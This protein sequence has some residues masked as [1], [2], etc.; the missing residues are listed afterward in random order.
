MDIND[1]IGKWFEILR[2][3]PSM[4]LTH[5]SDYKQFQNYVEGYI[6]GLACLSGKNIKL[7]L[8]KWFQNKY[9]QHSSLYW[10][11]HIAEMYKNRSTEELK[12]ILLDVTE[13]YFNENPL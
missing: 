7:E 13:E 4:I 5:N 1:K 10:V 12:T 6:D 9:K 3:S 2:N 8:T 11:D